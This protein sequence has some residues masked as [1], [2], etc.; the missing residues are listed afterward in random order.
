MN[1]DQISSGAL[2]DMLLDAMND[3][4]TGIPVNEILSRFSKTDEEVA[5]LN[6]E[7]DNLPGLFNMTEDEMSAEFNSI[8]EQ[9]QSVEV[10]SFPTFV[11]FCSTL[12]KRQVLIFYTKV[13]M[14]LMSHKIENLKKLLDDKLS[15][16]S[17]IV[18]FKK[19]SIQEKIELLEERFEE[20]I[21]NDKLTKKIFEQL[22]KELNND[23]SE[24]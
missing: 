3:L 7:A 6:L 22:K 8:V 2:T 20:E 13:M 23:E 24:S 9:M 11:Q 4:N 12:S 18:S 17:V 1:Q 19:K 16:N 14:D 15:N 10:N 5:A 21:K